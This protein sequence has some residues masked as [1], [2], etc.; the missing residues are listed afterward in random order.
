VSAA[1]DNTAVRTALW[2]AMHVLV[3]DPPHVLD[4]VL[5]LQLVAPDP[6]W[7]DR[8]DMHPDGT[9]G[10]RASIVARARFVED[11]VTAQAAAGVDQF[12]ILGAG[13]DTLAERRPDLAALLQI[14]EVDQPA[15]QA[16]K[17]DRLQA[18]GIGLPDALHLVPIDF[19]T[20]D[21]WWD[22]L[23]AAGFDPDRPAL[24]ASTGVSM[25]LTKVA[26]AAVLRQLAGLAAGSTVVMTFLVPAEL[27]DEADRPGLEASSQ[28]ARAAGTP[29]VSFYTP[30]EVLTMARAAGYADV[31]HVGTADLSRR[32]FAGRAD[33]LRPS[34]GEHLIVATT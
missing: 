6:G 32:Y 24:V 9:R 25:Y 20:D 21:N 2:R 1:P 27:V 11:L 3:D 26:T 14:F 8:P 34:S 5:G 15:T 16:W 7:R 4:D 29:F 19:E 10:F 12:V 18:T 22:G 33:G 13:L 17:R 31:R 23:R 28:G 30:D